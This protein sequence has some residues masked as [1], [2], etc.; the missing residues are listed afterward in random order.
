LVVTLW[1]R[2]NTRP[3]GHRTIY[4]S[5][6]LVTSSGHSRIESDRNWISTFRS[7]TGF[8]WPIAC[9]TALRTQKAKGSVRRIVRSHQN[10][11][12]VQSVWQL[13]C[14]IWHSYRL[15]PSTSYFSCQLQLIS[16]LHA[17][18]SSSPCILSCLYRTHPDDEQLLVRNMSRVH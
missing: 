15:V 5:V 11:G 7:T 1:R 9:N 18:Y 16:S 14:T 2:E 13:Y 8:N 6:F 3:A 17:P 4:P 10:S 12:P